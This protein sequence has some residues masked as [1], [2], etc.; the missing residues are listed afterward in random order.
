M[1]RKF[2]S[3]YFDD[4]MNGNY[5]LIDSMRQ[6]QESLW[7]FILSSE[8]V[9]TLEDFKIWKEEQEEMLMAAKQ[10]RIWRRNK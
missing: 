2:T 10:E 7:D 3:K 5:G 6:V 9:D 4:Y 1:E 8:K